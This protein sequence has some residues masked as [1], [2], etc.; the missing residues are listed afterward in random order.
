MLQ[1][2]IVTPS[3]VKLTQSEV[4]SEK[5]RIRR[6][7]K[8]TRDI[9]HRVIFK[10]YPWTYQLHE[11]INYFLIKKKKYRKNKNSTKNTQAPVTRFTYY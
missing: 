5:S 6:E 2:L 10:V 4:N 1:D 9:L 7:T 11:S 3:L 8:I